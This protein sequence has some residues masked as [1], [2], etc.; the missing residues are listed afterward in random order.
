[1][2]YTKNQINKILDYI[3]EKETIE[4]APELDSEH[5]NVFDCAFKPA[6]G[7]RSI[8]YTGHIKMMSAVQ[9]FI[10]GA[11]SKTVNMPELTNSNEIEEAYVY[12][13]EQGLK[14]IAIY[15]ENS[16]RSQP[17]NTQKTEGEL[18]K[19]KGVE[20]VKVI[21]GERKRMPRTR[22]SIVHKFDLAGHEGYLMVGLYDNGKP[23]E[24]FIS[25]SKEGSTIRGLMDVEGMLD[26]EIA[27]IKT[28][29]SIVDYV[30]QF[31][32]NNFGEGAKPMEIVVEKNNI[33]MP[34]EEQAS[35]TD[36]GHEG[37]ICPQCGG[38]AKRLGNC[39]IICTSCK[40]TTRSGCGE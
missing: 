18:I 22:K 28:A 1:L 29:S 5:L 10:S 30:A 9:P 14:A 12:A 15:R 23:G 7:Q 8:H 4:G 21:T 26:K 20:I 2:G 40:Q 13:W 24:V 3:N 39:A 6:N 34:K 35:I 17:L 16:K 33:E 19:K 25:M 11:I 27:Q 32:I 36:F 31:M 38:P 37:L